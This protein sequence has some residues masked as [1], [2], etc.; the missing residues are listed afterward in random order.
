MSPVSHSCIQASDCVLLCCASCDQ[1]KGLPAGVKHELLY[2]VPYECESQPIEQ[3]WRT[4]KSRVA[5]Q[6][7]NNRGAKLLLEQTVSAFY[8]EGPFTAGVKHTPITAERCKLW[9]TRSGDVVNGWLKEAVKSHAPIV[10]ELGP[11]S[12]SA[13]SSASAAA[14]KQKYVQQRKVNPSFDEDSDD[15]DL[16]DVDNSVAPAAQAPSS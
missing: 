7:T 15:D 5:G 1:S 4:V 12:L 8:D 6:H 13:G 14:W 3:L 9:I 11:I 16:P 2:T 10:Q